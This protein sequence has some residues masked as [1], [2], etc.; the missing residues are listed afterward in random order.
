MLYYNQ[1]HHKITNQLNK[2]INL[3]EARDLCRL[4]KKAHDLYCSHTPFQDSP[5]ISQRSGICDGHSKPLTLLVL[6]QFAT[7]LALY[8]GPLSIWKCQVRCSG[9]PQN[10]DVQE[11]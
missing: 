3:V 10:A 7:N 2:Q 9:G 5:Q 11:A 4:F 6:S 8:L 1:A